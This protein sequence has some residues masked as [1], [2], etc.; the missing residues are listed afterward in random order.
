MTRP[1][2]Y[3]ASPENYRRSF[4]L[5]AFAR[6][7]NAR[8]LTRPLSKLQVTVVKQIESVELRRHPDCQNDAENLSLNEANQVHRERNNPITIAG[9]GVVN[10][11]R[12]VHGY[13]KLSMIDYSEMSREE[14]SLPPIEYDTF[15]VYLC[16]DFT[17]LKA[18]LG[19]SYGPGVHGL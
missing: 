9:C 11:K 16:L 4:N 15:G 13:K 14:L 2:P 10:V 1:P 12:E 8:Y 19:D 17:T 7:S 3:I 6:P 5:A 18:F